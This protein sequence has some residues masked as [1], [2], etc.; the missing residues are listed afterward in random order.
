MKSRVRFQFYSRDGTLFTSRHH[1]TEID[2][3]FSMQIERCSNFLLFISYYMG[4]GLFMVRIKDEKESHLLP[5]HTKY[6]L[7]FARYLLA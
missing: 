3:V 1:Q 4:A 6:F 7:N 2:F 5:F